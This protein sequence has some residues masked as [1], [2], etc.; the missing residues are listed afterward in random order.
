MGKFNNKKIVILIFMLG[1]LFLI[2]CNSEENFENK[3]IEGI[4]SQYIYDST[5]SLYN[6][7]SSEDGYYITTGA[8]IYY[9]DKETKKQGILCNKPNCLHDEEFD[10]SKKYNCNG[11]L[12]AAT[13]GSSSLYYYKENIYALVNFNPMK[14]SHDEEHSLIKISKDGE[15]REV[16]YSF[17]NKISN[18]LIHR[19]YFYYVSKN[20]ESNGNYSCR[21]TKLL[22][23]NIDKKNSKPEIVQENNL[24]EDSIT[25]MKAYGKNIYFGISGYKEEELSTYKS[26]FYKYDIEKQ[27][28]EEVFFTE[29]EKEVSKISIYKDKILYYYG[30]YDFYDERNKEIYASDLNGE[31]GKLFLKIDSLWDKDSDDKFIIVD[32]KIQ[33]KENQ[34][35]N[36]IIEFYDDSGEKVDFIDLG[37]EEPE[38]KS[39]FVITGDEEYSFLSYVDS[40][41]L[42]IKTI[43]KKEIGSEN[44]KLNDFFKVKLKNTDNSISY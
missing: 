37:R 15:K 33:L 31:K 19:G 24:F 10:S 17:D 42:Y 12:W 1:S 6:I 38:A 7:A 8:Y 35:V 30:H 40:E 25:S 43:D 36:R 39:W 41:Y 34:S 13:T 32:N 4:D 44:L 27:K 20:L 2:G 22:R 14:K 23:L 3:F 18:A 5:F 26:G 29:E 21:N 9:V 16:I 11:F 28:V